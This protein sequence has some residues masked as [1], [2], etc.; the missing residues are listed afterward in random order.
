M[1]MGR[2]MLKTFIKIIK[3][4]DENKLLT[5]SSVANL[6]PIELETKNNITRTKNTIYIYT[7]L[8][9]SVCETYIYRNMLKKK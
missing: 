2:K 1:T 4:N 8:K 9:P 3:L 5:A 7:V 6:I